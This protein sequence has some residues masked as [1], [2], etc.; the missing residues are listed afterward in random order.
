MNSSNVSTDSEQ[1]ALS[2]MKLLE[3]Y[4]TDSKSNRVIIDMAGVS[5][6]AL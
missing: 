3:F 1:V 5:A 6:E 4:T 2:V